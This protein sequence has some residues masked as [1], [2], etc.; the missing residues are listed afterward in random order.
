MKTVRKTVKKTRT[1]HLQGIINLYQNETG[2]VQIDLHDVASWAVRKRLWE[3][4]SGDSIQQCAHELSRAARKEQYEDPQG[5][6][7]RKKHAVRQYIHEGSSAGKQLILWAD[8]ET[9]PPDHMRISL[10]QRRG[11]IL[12]DCR[13]LKTDLE[14]YNENNKHGACIQLSFDFTEDLEEAEMDTE[15]PEERPE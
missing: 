3:P 12:G 11:Y 15:Y 9:A 6:T 10:Q 2:Q 7:V 14:S 4:Q 13:Q 1:E 8:I 5:R